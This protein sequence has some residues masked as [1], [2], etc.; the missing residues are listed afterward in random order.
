MSDVAQQVLFA[1][2][3]GGVGR[4]TDLA[5]ALQI[6][7]QGGLKGRRQVAGSDGYTYELR[8]NGVAA[9]LERLECVLRF[10]GHPEGDIDF[11]VITHQLVG[12]LMDRSHQQHPEPDLPNGFWQWLLVERRDS[13]EQA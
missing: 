13:P 9:P 2:Y 5:A 6:L 10:P 7:G 11:S 3:C 1:P 4:E 8:W 12:W